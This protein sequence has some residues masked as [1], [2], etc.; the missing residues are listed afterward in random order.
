M[1]KDKKFVTKSMYELYTGWKP[2]ERTDRQ[3]LAQKKRVKH[4]WTKRRKDEE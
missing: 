4:N 1:S 2:T 3:K